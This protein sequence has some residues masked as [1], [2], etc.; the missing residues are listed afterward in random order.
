L[1]SVIGKPDDIVMQRALVALLEQQIVQHRANLVHL[2]AAMRL[3]DPN[4]APEAISARSQRP[5]SAWFHPGECLRLI[6]GVLRETPAPMVGPERQL[7]PGKQRA[8][9]DREVAAARL[10]AP[11][12]LACKP[13]A[14]VADRAAAIWTYRFAVRFGPAQ[15]QEHVLDPAVG[16]A[17]DLGGTK[18]TRANRKQEMLRHEYRSRED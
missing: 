1:A 15:A 16:H 9:G 13:T 14:R 17:H 11:S 18:R 12:Q 4:R 3:F 2:D 5:R 6:Y 10:A 8:R 7:A